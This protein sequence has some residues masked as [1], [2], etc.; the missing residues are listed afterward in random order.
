LPFYIIF[1]QKLEDDMKILKSK[2]GISDWRLTEL[3]NNN[4]IARED[5]FAIIS[6]GG[7]SVQ[8]FS[9]FYYEE[10]K[11]GDENKSS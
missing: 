4:Q 9:I 3:V 2:I 10:S 1:N 5:I 11:P 6:N 7:G 8:Q